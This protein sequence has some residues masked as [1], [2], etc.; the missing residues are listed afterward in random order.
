MSQRAS[1]SLNAATLL[2]ASRLPREFFARDAVTVARDL[3]GKLLIRREGRR[4]LAGR[5][6]E[7]EAYLGAIDPAAHAYNGRTPR[8]AV[9]FGP[10]G[11]AYVYFIYGNHYCTNVSC[12]PEGHAGCVLLR[13]LE[14]VFGL[15]AM[16]AVRG[17]E[18]PPQLPM[19]R[20]RMLSSG[21]GRMS[22][23]LGITLA[24]DNGKDLTHPR[25]GLWLADDG[26][27]VERIATTTRIGIKKAVH[28]PLRFV[29]AGNP[30]VSGPRAK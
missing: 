14:P 12:M 19:S 7:D 26:Y 30:F 6:V 2:A 8:N 20:L 16:A 1:D 9:L 18:L 3:L 24:R 5:I 4:L 11:H 29:I 23:A 22:Q 13:A 21:P 10:P 28:E 25:S 15:D 17:L 27:Q